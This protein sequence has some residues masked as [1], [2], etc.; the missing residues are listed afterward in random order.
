MEASLQ[1]RLAQYN[2]R[3]VIHWLDVIIE[4]EVSKAALERRFYAEDV[5]D[6]VTGV[7]EQVVT[8]NSK[9]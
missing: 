6:L 4:R 7:I 1:L 5:G 3:D 9:Q 8:A 2:E